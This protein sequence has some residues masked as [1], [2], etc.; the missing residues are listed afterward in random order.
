MAKGTG[1]ILED[2]TPFSKGKQKLF[3][4]KLGLKK[5]T[6]DT[7]AQE[8]ALEQ[9]QLQQA[10]LDEEENRRRKRLLAA[11]TGIRAFAGSPMFRR[12]AGNRAG[13]AYNG[14]TTASRP[15]GA[16]YARGGSSAGRGVSMIP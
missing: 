6:V 14:G 12:Q 11:S 4:D 2:A 10:A 13:A 8:A 1:N 9:Q 5:P 16:S 7:S 3:K 15:F